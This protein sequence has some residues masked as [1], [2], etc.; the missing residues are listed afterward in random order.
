MSPARAPILSLALLAAV[1]AS[2]RVQADP[3][4]DATLAIASFEA[5]S[6]ATADDAALVADLVTA[7][8]V[9]EGKI[10]VVE[11]AELAKVMKEQALAASGAMSDVNRIKVAQLVGARWILVGTI[12]GHKRGFALGA[13]AIDSS[14][15][16][17]A[18]ADSVQVES[19]TCCSAGARQLA[20]KLQDKLVGGSS[21]SAAIDDFNPAQVKEA[22]RQL[23]Q[24]IAV[25]FSKL[26]GHL[27][28]V[29]PNNTASCLFADSKL[30]FN[31]QRFTI[32]G[33]DSVTEQDTQKGYFLI[34]AVSDKGCLGRI[35]RSGG[36]EVSNGDSIHSLPLQVSMAALAVGAGTD[37]QVGQNPL[38][39]GARVAQEPARLRG[40]RGRPGESGGPHRRRARP[41]RDRGAG[42]RQERRGPAAVGPERR[43]LIGNLSGSPH[44]AK[45]E[46]PPLALALRA[47]IEASAA[48][49]H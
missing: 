11:R 9:N 48:I 24:Q 32:S 22:A 34:T 3:A 15:G 6:G 41:P 49:T 18:F 39:R 4:P 43:V 21:A 2:A 20:H 25:R 8:L 26:E 45:L 1:T 23:A 37:A 12:Q 17:V 5:R 42:A 27:G 13:R 47:S 14:G 28:E 16:Q 31:G 35:K 7:T 30:A 44:R 38:A 36:D 19:R 29:L 33:H 10:R 46:E 40:G